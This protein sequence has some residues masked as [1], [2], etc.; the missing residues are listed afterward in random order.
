MGADIFVQGNPGIEQ[1]IAT[2]LQ[3]ESQPRIALED[4]KALLNTRNTV[5]SDLDSKLS[6]LNSAAKRLTDPLTNY[7]AA[8][9]VASSDADL[10]TALA[11]SSAIAGSHDVTIQRLASSD[12]RVSKQYT[13]AGTSLVS[14]FSTNGSQTF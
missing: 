7:F 3:L 4:K 8:K 13:S 2:T 11:D 14:F 5:L 1:L 6:A 12:T 9:N 10:L